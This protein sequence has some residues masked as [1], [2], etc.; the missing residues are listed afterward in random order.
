MPSVFHLIALKLH[1]IKNNPKREITDFPDIIRLIS[2]NNIDVD[3]GDFRALC[4]RFGT[5]D[6]YERIKK[7]I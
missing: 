5:E 4:L 3:S 2:Y 6:L 1:S 7:S